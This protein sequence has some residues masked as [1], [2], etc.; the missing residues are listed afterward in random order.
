M[1]KSERVEVKNWKVAEICNHITILYFNDK[2]S[3]F[4]WNECLRLHFP[5]CTLQM[6]E[7]RPYLCLVVAVSLEFQHYFSKRESF[8]KWQHQHRWYYYSNILVVSTRYW[9]TH[10]YSLLPNVSDFLPTTFGMRLVVV[11]GCRVVKGQK[12]IS[13]AGLRSNRPW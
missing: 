12:H 9:C 10:K 7:G 5:L 6:A 1:I 11:V 4:Q 8:R 3:I 2:Y 13:V